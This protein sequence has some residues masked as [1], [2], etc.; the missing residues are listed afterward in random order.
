MQTMNAR[1]TGGWT[2]LALT[3]LLVLA[4]GGVAHGKRKKAEELPD[5]DAVFEKY[6][7]AIGGREAYLSHTNVRLVGNMVLEAQGITA[8]LT[9]RMQA[10]NLIHQVVEIP[11]IGRIV[12]GYDGTV[13]WETNP[14][15]G[16]RLLA[17]DEL[18]QMR[19][20]SHFHA[21]A[22]MP[23]LYPTRETVGR[24]EFEGQPALKVR[25]VSAGGLEKFLYFDPDTGLQLGFEKQLMT[26]M[27]PM[28]VVAVYLERKEI[29]GLLIET[30]IVERTGPMVAVME[31]TE[32][33]F[34]VPD[35]GTFEPSPDVLELLQEQIP[36]APETAPTE[37]I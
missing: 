18:E 37:S 8:T 24:V 26:D 19:V 17:G 10:P 7:E 14:L 2:T 31:L 28:P 25:V 12:Q 1:S 32:F 21:P 13:G 6:L 20:D 27:G 30:K 5:A 3:A 16:P 11:G 35:I 22:M 9:G 33:N 15:T 23:E 36:T 4:V 29:G 34:D